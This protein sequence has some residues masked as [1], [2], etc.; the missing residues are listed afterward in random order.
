[1]SYSSVND[2]YHVVL[3]YTFSLFIL[4]Y[5]CSLHSMVAD[6]AA[7]AKS[8]QSCLT[9]CN[10]IDGSPPGC[11]AIDL[12]IDIGSTIFSYS[13]NLILMLFVTFFTTS[14]ICCCYVLARY[15]GGNI[16]P[17]M[18][19]WKKQAKGK[20]TLQKAGNIEVPK[21]AFIKALKT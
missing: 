6:A 12:L 8:L 1:M 20:K 7:A 19:L 13:I 15:Y 4:I 16:T 21:D 17:E 2:I 10:P 14:E 3:Y 5:R 9:L 18:K 11:T